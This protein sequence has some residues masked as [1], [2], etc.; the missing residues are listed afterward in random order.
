MKSK[1]LISLFSGCGGMDLGFHGDFNIHTSIVNPNIHT[2]WLKQ[3]KK[4]WVTLERTGFEIVFANDILHSAEKA[5]TSYFTKKC[6]HDIFINKDIVDVVKNMKLEKST[7]PQ[8]IDIVIGGFP[9]QDFSVAGKRKGFQSHKST[10][11]T[12]LSTSDTN[13]RGTLYKWF[14][15][16]ISLT[17]PKIFIAENVKGLLTIPNAIDT[18]I[19]DFQNINDGFIA[20]PIQVLNAKEYGI[21]QNRE[22][23][24]II[25]INKKYIKHDHIL[26]DIIN[27][28]LS[29]YPKPTHGQEYPYTTL[30]HIFNDLPEPEKALNDKAQ[31]SYSRA[32]FT[33]GKQGNIEINLNGVSPTIRAEHHGNIEYRRLSNE[34]GGKIARESHLLERRLTVRECA[35]IQT[36]PDDYQFVD[37][38]LGLS[39]SSAYKIIGNAVPPVLAYHIAKHIENIWD[40][41]FV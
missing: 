11:N 23:I 3:E 18:I 24:F 19:E 30:K 17:N 22:R 32:K 38:S 26:Q 8:K 12:I 15:E 37:S 25:C 14:K 16:V 21:P 5:W 39:A 41:I 20:A 33:K 1:R 4:H 40:D 9:C 36:F 27:G 29:L 6:G 28:S 34:N 31:Q 35:R 7:I 2:S 13:N 10:Q